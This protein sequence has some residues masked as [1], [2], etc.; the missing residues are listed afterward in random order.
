MKLLRQAAA[1]HF[2]GG[3]LKK[4][5]ECLEQ[6]LRSD[7]SDVTTMARLVLLYSQVNM[8]KVPRYFATV[9]SLIDLEHW[10]HNCK[11]NQIDIDID[12]T[13]VGLQFDPEAAKK[14]SLLLPPLELD[15]GVAALD[16]DALETNTWAIG[17]KHG[18][19]TPASGGLT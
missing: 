10:N 19:K 16:V 18:K 5:T 11:Y 7:P 17:L 12:L 15:S 8:A 4:S 3:E 1:F 9:P 6:V 14:K 13:F 2:K